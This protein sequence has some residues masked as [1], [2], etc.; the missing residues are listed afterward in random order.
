[1]DKLEGLRK[2]PKLAEVVGGWEEGAGKSSEDF[3]SPRD[4]ALCPLLGPL[5][6]EAA[7]PHGPLASGR[8]ASGQGQRQPFS[9]LGSDCSQRGAAPAV[10]LLRVPSLGTERARLARHAM[11]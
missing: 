9:S 10:T 5:Q 6:A 4:L 2:S 8:T 3:P 11:L 7:E 1:M